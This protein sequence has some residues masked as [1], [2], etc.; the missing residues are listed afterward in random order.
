MERSR[1]EGSARM[2]LMVIATHADKDAL[3]THL[4]LD[5]LCLESNMKRRNLIYTLA[6]LETSGELKIDH[7][8]GSGNVNGYTLTLPNVQPITPLADDQ[9]GESLSPTPSEIVQPVAPLERC[10][11]SSEKVQST[12]KKV[13]PIV[14][15]VQ[16]IAPVPIEPEIQPEEPKRKTSAPAARVEDLE[17]PDWLP[18]DSWKDWLTHRKELK[19]PVTATQARAQFKRLDNFRARGMPPDA[20]IEQAIANG[21]RGFYELQPEGNNGNAKSGG[22]SQTGEST[23]LQ[24][25]REN[26]ERF[27][28]RRAS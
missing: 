17:L 13:Q 11:P 9:Q 2:V 1:S 26:Y 14:E 25:H 19:K 6:K 23:N 24:R 27:V 21:W 18:P 15:N 16:P 20:V 3:S 22:N 7:A 5:R 10:N 8:R 4:G 12:V 28:R